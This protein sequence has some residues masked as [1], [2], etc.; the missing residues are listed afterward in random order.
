MGNLHPRIKSLVGQRL[1]KAARNVA[2]GHTNEPHTGPVLE[3]CTVYS[4]TDN[5]AF[6]N[7][8]LRFRRDILGGDAV[9]VNDPL[10]RALEVGV[11]PVSGWYG[12]AGG[13]DRASLL[14]NLGSGGP[15]Q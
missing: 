8:T 9:M 13:A 11:D 5:G 12:G 2:Y 15:M 3:S 7:I 10:T 4:S 6:P 1:A 14:A